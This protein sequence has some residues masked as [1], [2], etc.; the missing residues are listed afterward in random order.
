[1]STAFIV[2][3]TDAADELKTAIVVE[4]G[5]FWEVHSTDFE[6]EVT[7][8]IKPGRW[9]APSPACASVDPSPLGSSQPL[10]TRAFSTVTPWR[11]SCKTAATT[12]SNPQ[13][14]TMK[15]LFSALLAPFFVIVNVVALFFLLA[16]C[17]VVIA[18][19][20]IAAI[21]ALPFVLLLNFFEADR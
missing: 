2:S 21:V 1:M 10:P 4:G 15:D 17:P 5:D 12:P 19:A 7:T 6:G 11:T 8:S 3:T 13:L 20:A 14:R 9:F 18:V 16:A